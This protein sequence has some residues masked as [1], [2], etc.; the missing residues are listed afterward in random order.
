M[1]TKTGFDDGAF[2]DL[3]AQHLQAVAATVAARQS[4]REAELL[5][6]QGYE[7]SRAEPA[8]KLRCRVLLLQQEEELRCEELE[9]RLAEHRTSDR[10]PLG[11]DVVA[12]T[13][14]LSCEEQLV[15]W[16]TTIACLG[17]P[18]AEATL[19]ALFT[20]Y[21]GLQVGDAAQLLGAVSPSDWVRCRRLFLPSSVLLKEGIL[22]YDRPPQGLEELAGA[23]LV[24]TRETFALVT[25]CDLEPESY[26][27][28]GFAK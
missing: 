19:G 12:E 6:R 15:L 18:A 26:E 7:S 10:P 11:I 4:L 27:P 16:A 24:V 9:A 21:N 14:R 13:Y 28:V 5:S 25:G 2:L 23:T 20:S 8:D 1:E 17:H 22:K 3:A